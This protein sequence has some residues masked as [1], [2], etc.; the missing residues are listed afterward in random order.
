M[1]WFAAEKQKNLQRAAAEE[2]EQ[3]KQGCTG[4]QDAQGDLSPWNFGKGERFAKNLRPD[5]RCAMMQRR[6][7]DPGRARGG[8]R[9]LFR[10]PK[11]IYGKRVLLMQDALIQLFTEVDI[12]L[13]RQWL[14]KGGLTIGVGEFVAF[15]PHRFEAQQVITK[16]RN[17]SG[18]L[19]LQRFHFL[20]IAG[21]AMQFAVTFTAQLLKAAECFEQTGIQ[22]E[23]RIFGLHRKPPEMFLRERIDTL[24]FFIINRKQLENKAGSSGRRNKSRNAQKRSKRKTASEEAVSW[25]G[26]GV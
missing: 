25:L 17:N 12:R 16:L 8:C 26:A 23:I 24:F 3:E 15:M 20:N 7:I 2:Q 1:R 19:K 22:G 18:S 5:A 21:N 4:K 10:L 14:Q 11:G 13:F 9:G 6:G